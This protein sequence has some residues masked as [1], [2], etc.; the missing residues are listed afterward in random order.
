MP[1]SGSLKDRRRVVKGMKDR[2]RSRFN[3]SVAEVGETELWQRATLGI[4]CV[5]NDRAHASEVLDKVVDLVR[6]N[7]SAGLIDYGVEFL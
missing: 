1:G 7:T 4:A 5:S 6:S 2:I 3:V